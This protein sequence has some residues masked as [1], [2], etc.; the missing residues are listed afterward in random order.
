MSTLN[1]NVEHYRTLLRS[2]ELACELY[3]V[4]NDDLLVGFESGAAKT[5]LQRL[6]SWMQY[7]DQPEESG[8][9][10][11]DCGGSGQGITENHICR[12]CGGSG[13]V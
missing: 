6:I 1:I 10:C 4:W 2:H 5:R 13:E 9:V 8:E 12:T 11:P 7:L 3:E